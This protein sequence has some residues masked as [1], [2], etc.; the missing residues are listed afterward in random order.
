MDRPMLRA[1]TLA[2]LLIVTAL[3]V[4]A[5][6]KEGI[7][8]YE[9]GDYT[10]ALREMKPLAEQGD[11]KA[12]NYL[13]QMYIRGHGVPKNHREAARWFRK[14][15][16]QG[17]A[18]ARHNL[19]LMYYTGRGVPKNYKLAYMWYSLAAAQGHNAAAKFIEFLEK[20]MTPADV[21]RAQAMATKW[22][23]KKAKQTK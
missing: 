3:P 4:T 8:A 23:P 19:G 13:G 22:K 16:E 11:A 6:F 17:E 2:V 5:G 12:Q 21:S 9:R 15:A 18:D 14:A 20:C 10:T 1:L 7:A